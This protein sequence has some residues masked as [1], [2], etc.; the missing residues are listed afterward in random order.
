MN[1][2]QVTGDAKI[3]AIQG[4]VV[5]NNGLIT[6]L[7]GV[8]SQYVR[9]DGTLAD[10]P[11]S[12][13]GGSS[14]SYYLN[15][16]VSQGTIG[17]NAYRQLSK[18][19]VIGSGTDI[20][21]SS[22]G[23]I[24]NY[25]TDANDPSLINVPAGNF[26]CEFYFSVNSN[27]HNPNVYAELYKYDGTS[28]TLLGSN[29]A[30]PEYLV[31]GTT[32]SAY[33]F[34]IPVAFA[35][36]N[37]TDRLAIR[38][39]A[40]VDTKIVTLHTEDNHLCQLITTFSKGLTSLNGLTAQVQYFATGTSGTD[41]SISSATASHTFNLPIASTT[42]TGKLS[43]TDF[44]TF[45]NKV[46][47]TGATA[48]LNLGQNL[49]INQA[50]ASGN[51]YLYT[52]YQFG[53]SNL[54]FSLGQTSTDSGY[55]GLNN[56]SGGLTTFL[57]GSG[58]SYI[59]NTF[60]LLINTDIP[61]A[62]GAFLQ[63]NG[64]ISQSVISS[65]IKSDSN[66]KLIAAVAGTDYLAPSGL[67]GYIKFLLRA[68]YALMIA[69]GTPSVTTIYTVTNDENKSYVRSTYLWK[70]DGNREWIASIPDN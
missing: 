26:N 62:S 42:N 69:D 34:S 70:T 20:S 50:N 38:I 59:N 68:T 33:Y 3:R 65:I 47:Y 49:F 57:N 24:A 1:Q 21:I 9:G 37:I 67:S 45:K 27:N 46:P 61:N 51:S 36:L 41:F 30:I 48:S 64:G 43:S 53:T 54:L 23:Y 10:F 7:N 40:N 4:P 5:A 39:Y 12:T 63:V 31:N 6:A 60:P 14:V 16:S 56:S 52:G 58:N 15:S 28:F 44:T 18:T 32:L 29:V 55:F 17:G 8:V 19:P 25:I 66:G 2:L 11:I 13:G 22:N 35:S